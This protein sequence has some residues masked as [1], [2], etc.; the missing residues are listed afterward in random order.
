MAEKCGVCNKRI[1]GAFSGVPAAP[2]WVQL[3]RQY[4]PDLPES[5]CMDCCRENYRKTLDLAVAQRDKLDDEISRLCSSITL[6]TLPPPSP[7]Y[8][9]LGLITT[10]VALGTG[11]LSTIFSSVTD[12]FGKESKAYKEKFDL[13]VAKCQMDLREMAVTKG[14]SHI[15]GAHITYTELTS[16]HGMLL[17]YA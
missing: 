14:A 5:I 4:M 10:Q 9:D 11:P 17:I 2:E 6:N 3:L 8:V 1:S 16:G 7:E 12:L 15:C 13:A